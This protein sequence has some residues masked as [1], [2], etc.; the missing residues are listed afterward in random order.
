M[1]T[2]QYTYLEEQYGKEYLETIQ[3]TNQEFWKTHE[4]EII[5]S[6]KTNSTDEFKTFFQQIPIAGDNN[7]I[8]TLEDC[9]ES[10]RASK[11][12]TSLESK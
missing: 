7:C 8:T 9:E 6:I 5:R 4:T 11:L 1:Q 3:T 2:K 12:S 10:Q